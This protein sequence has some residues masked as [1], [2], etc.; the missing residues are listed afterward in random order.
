MQATGP[1]RSDAWVGIVMLI[2]DRDFHPHPSRPPP[3]KKK[4]FDLANLHFMLF[5]RYENNIQALGFFT[6]T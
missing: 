4:Y 1:P 3:K 6:V 2:G 5:D